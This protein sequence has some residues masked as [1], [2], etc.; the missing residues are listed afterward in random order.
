[1]RLRNCRLRTCSPPNDCLR[2]PE[3]VRNAASV[4]GNTL[5]SAPRLHSLFRGRTDACSACRSSS[6]P[7][8]AENA[9]RA[10]AFRR[11]CPLPAP[12]ALHPASC[13][14]HARVTLLRMSAAGG[15]PS[16]LRREDGRFR[17]PE[18]RRGSLPGELLHSDHRERKRSIPERPPAGRDPECTFFVVVNR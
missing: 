2:L 4:H 5:P 11:R 10:A 3:A 18:R 7:Q 12:Y 1:M 8:P 16:C 9:A 6:K 13:V 14:S 17:S 15:A